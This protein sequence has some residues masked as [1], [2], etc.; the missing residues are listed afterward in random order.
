MATL[1]AP[2]PWFGGKSRCADKVW[3]ALGDVPNYVEPFAGSLAVL[4][5]R[6][7]DHAARV[8]TV[9]D[10]DCFVANFWRALKQDPDAV[11]RWASDPVNECDLT[12]RH[13]WLV[14]HWPDDR[15]KLQADPSHYNAQVAGWWVWGQCAWIGS[16]W[17]SG[18]GPWS[19]DG[20]RLVKR[21]R[22]R[23]IIRQIPH[24]GDT[25]RGINRK[26]PHLS[27]QHGI[28]EYMSELARRLER[29]R[30][31]CGDWSRVVTRGATSY[32]R[33][34]PVGVLLDPPYSGAVR[35]RNLYAE[36]DHDVSADVREWCIANGD[37]PRLRIVLAGY[38]NEHSMPEGWQE[39]RW[40]AKRAYGTTTSTDNGNRKRERLWLSPHCADLST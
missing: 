22:V 10:I 8:E 36:D 37:D 38:D 28:L 16:G 19:S 12:A 18:R 5:A 15:E 9:N 3:A 14:S 4:L 1:K 13:A 20:D 34:G 23:G 33:R 32:P 40:T 24:L 25:G 2:F 30:V 17:C 39:V 7:D 11:A 26:L 27:R 35:T 21:G 31:C 29:V 6:P